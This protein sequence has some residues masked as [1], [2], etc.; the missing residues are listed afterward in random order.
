[1]KDANA[2]D[3]FLLIPLR[4][5]VSFGIWCY[6]FSGDKVIWRGETYQL[7]PNGQLSQL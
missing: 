1:L 7:L 4:D 3:F 2:K 6:S 5:F